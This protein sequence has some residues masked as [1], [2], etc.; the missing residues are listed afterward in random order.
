MKTKFFTFFVA[1]FATTCLWAYDFKSGDL[2]YNITS[3]VEPYTVEVTKNGTYRLTSVTIPSTVYYGGTTYAVTSIGEYAFYDC[4]SLTSV[5][6]GDNVTSIG[7]YAFYYCSSLTS[8]AWNAIKCTDFSSSPFYPNSSIT[9][10]IF[11]EK[12]EHIPANLCSNM[13]SLTSVT[14]PNSVT[15]I[16]RS[17]FNGCEA[18]TKTN[19]TGDVAAWCD[20]KF[21]SS[22]SNPMSYSHNFYINDQEIKDLVIP[23]T[24]DS[25]Y[26]Y[27]FYGCSSLT[28]VTIPNSVTSIGYYA[29]YDCTSLTSIT[30]PNSVTSIGSSAFYNCCFLKK[31]FINN[32]SLDAEKNNYWGALVGDTEVDGLIISGTTIVWAKKHL[33]AATIPNYITTIGYYAFY[34]CSSLTSIT[35]P[36]SVTS[37]GSSAFSDCVALT[38]TNYMGD[39]AGWCDINFSSSTSNPMSYSHNFYINDQEIKDLVIPNTVDTIHNYAF[40]E[41]SSLTTVTIPNSVTSIGNNAFS[42]CSSITS[43]TIPNSVTSIGNNAFYNCSSL[44]SIKIPESVINIGNG[45]FDYTAFYNDDSNWEDNVLYIDNCLISIQDLTI[46]GEY[47]IK[48][49]VRLIAGQGFG[50][51]LDLTSVVIPNSVKSISERAFTE[52]GITS[53]VIPDNV[54]NMEKEA[55]WYCKNLSSV[56]IGKGIT[57]LRNRLFCGCYALTSIDIPKNITNMEEGVFFDCKN[58]SSVTLGNSI[59]S[60]AD[61]LFYGCNALTHINIPEGVKNIGRYAFRG[62]KALE[63]VVL[64]SKTPPTLDPTAFQ[65]ATKP[66]CY[67]PCGSLVAYQSSDWNPCADSFIESCDENMKIVYTSSNGEIVTPYKLE[68]LGAKILDNIYEDGQGIITCQIPITQIGDSAFYNCSSLTSITIPNSVTHIGKYAFSNCTL[69]ASIELSNR[70]TSIEEKI[71]SNCSTLTEIAIPNSVKS[72]GYAAF[73]NCIRLSKIHIGSTMETIAKSAFAGCKRLYDIYCYAAYPPFAEESSFANYNVYLYVPCEKQRDYILDVVWGNFKF[74]ECISS[75]NVETD[76]VVITPTTNDVTIMWPTESNAD[77]YT[78]VIKKGDEIFCTLTFNANGQ[79]L[80]IAFAPSRDGNHRGAQYAE[81]AGNGYR[82]TV[83]G[84]QQATKYEYTI[85]ANDAADQTIQSYSGEFT[86]KSNTPTS[87]LDTQSQPTSTQKFLRNGQLLI[88]REGKTYNVMGAQVD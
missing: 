36:N 70:I 42:Y 87:V 44:M 76:G 35:I 24:V 25:I 56:S 55:F 12:V 15:S 30:I 20:I 52:S 82:F 68:A 46:S 29:F 4:F 47:R 54:T 79:L 2:Y 63:H 27:A 50:F 48:D 60:I 9:S 86:T 78:I 77:T 38:K 74:I 21:D 71:F 83:T 72:I 33:N 69:L 8:I 53:V 85:S 58:L 75:D 73:E 43:V 16:G 7:E 19:Y 65:Y 3:N 80:N 18:L 26:N 17:A 32:S 14:I 88:L 61:Q 28:S 51:Q 84:L 64:S 45:A 5:I 39:V 13:D 22:S 81:Q 37:I 62:C 49:G 40:Y 23:N 11:G 66:V 31:D 41:C 1:L 67:I 6:I 57:N 10:F 34:N 59:T